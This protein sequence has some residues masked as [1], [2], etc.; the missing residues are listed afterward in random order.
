[1]KCVIWYNIT[2]RMFNCWVTFKENFDNEIITE[3]YL[4]VYLC[5]NESV[6]SNNIFNLMF[7]G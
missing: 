3:E 4:I 5:S 2:Q 6:V 7:N 1:M